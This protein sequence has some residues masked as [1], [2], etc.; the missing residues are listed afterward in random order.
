LNTAKKK[1]KAVFV[2]ITANGVAG[3]DKATQIVNEAHA[4]YKKSEIITINRDVAEN[5][6]LVNKY[7]IGSVKVPF[8]IVVSPKGNLVGRF[9]LA[10]ANTDAL[11]NSIPSPKKDVVL[12][13]V[14]EKKPVF[15]VVS[16]KGFTDK[17]TVLENC[18]SASLKIASKPIIIEIDVD[19]AKESEF[20]KE[21]GVATNNGKTIT[22]VSNASGQVTDKFEGITL[23]TA[24]IASANKVIR[25]GC[26]SGCGSSCGPKK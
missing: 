25:S 7:R 26:G 20:L 12:T 8:I 4:K 1:G 16:K 21:L 18:K 15:I 14:T 2:L 19:D 3:V 5:S 10:Q 23:E 22:V 9:M 17:A 11:V 6:D 13:A 24:L